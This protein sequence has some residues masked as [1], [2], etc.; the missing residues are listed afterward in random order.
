MVMLALVEACMDYAEKIRKIRQV[1]GIQRNCQES[2]T[3]NE[4]T[5]IIL[6][7]NNA[8]SLETG[9]LIIVGIMVGIVVFTI[10][11]FWVNQG[12]K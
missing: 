2:H 6:K 5:H 11:F 12:K 3:R 9:F 10:A 7:I 8:Y 1:T 4:M